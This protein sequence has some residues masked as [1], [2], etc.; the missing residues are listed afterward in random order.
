MLTPWNPRLGSANLVNALASSGAVVYIGGVFELVNAVIIS[1]TGLRGEGRR[2]L[3]AVDAGTGL[4]TPWNP[5]VLEGK[6]MALSIAGSVVYA[7]GSFDQVG[8][9]GQEAVRL[10]LAAFD[11]GSGVV[12]PWDPVVRGIDGDVV[13]AM[14]FSGRLV[15]AGGRF[16]EIGGQP[17]D[18]LA[19]LDADTGLATSWN[20]PTNDAVSTFFDDGRRLYIGGLFTTIGEQPRGRLASVDKATG[21]LTSWDP[22]ADGPVRTIL[23]SNGKVF[24]GG[25]F[26]TI[27]GRPRSMFAVIDADTGLVVRSE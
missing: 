9:V 10:N 25:D 4:A 12:L 22:N 24:V 21:L 20:F 16:R 19:S 26:T 6:V 8:V 27:G 5:N 13:S 15:Y 11:M 18:N 14:D 3:A 2:N 1:G 7:G 17:R 23:A